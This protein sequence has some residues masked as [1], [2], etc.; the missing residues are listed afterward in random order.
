MGQ[1]GCTIKR[2]FNKHLNLFLC[3]ILNPI[4]FSKFKNNPKNM[5]KYISGILIL[6]L[7]IFISCKKKKDDTPAPSG[8]VAITATYYIQANIAG[9]VKTFQHNVGG[10]S[11]GAGGSGT[12]G[13]NGATTNQYSSSFAKYSIGGGG[14]VVAN[15]NLTVTFNLNSLTATQNDYDVFFVA[16]AKNYVATMDDLNGVCIEWMDESGVVWS[17]TAGAQTGTAAFN[18]TATGSDVLNSMN[19]NWVQA[20]FNCTLW[21]PAGTAS[22]TVTNGKVKGI[23]LPFQ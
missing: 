11:N 10:Y 2:Y 13:S 3:E 9:T 20:T 1:N 18:I 12:A 6:C 5:K 15:D 19:V 16:G 14:L 7:G 8:P 4:Y 23:T 22:K 21:N 17:T